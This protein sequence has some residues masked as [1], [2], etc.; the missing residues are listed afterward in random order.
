MQR[1]TIEKLFK[2]GRPFSPIYSAIMKARAFFYETGLLRSLKVKA[3]VISIGNISLGGTGKTPHVIEIAKFLRKSG[4]TP[5]IV[6]RGYGGKAGKGPVIVTDGK[7]VLTDVSI[8]GDEPYMMAKTLKGIPI[9]VGSNRSTSASYAIKHL[10]A[11]S[12][13]LDDGFQHLAL[14][15]DIDIVLLPAKA[16]F[17]NQRVFPGGDL[18]EPISGVKRA[19]CIILTKCNEITEADLQIEKRE[20]QERFPKIPI[21]ESSYS[22]KFIELPFKGITLSSG[23]IRE[24]IFIFCGIANPISFIDLLKKEDIKIA[25]Y[26]FF[27]DHFQYD[28]KSLSALFK[29]IKKSGSSLTLTTA[30]DF[31]KI[32]LED[33]ERFA[34]NLQLGVVHLSTDIQPSFWNFLTHNLSSCRGG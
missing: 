25:G 22:V 29:D 26:R 21:F 14:R 18:R 30:K 20:L 10:N 33:W 12:I 15:R 6:S 3:P 27:K 9:L 13:I 8:C 24:K 32:A 34:P 31:A 1:D 17:G 16:P 7:K 28:S 11:D 5:A 23:E 19:S 2:L 4:Y